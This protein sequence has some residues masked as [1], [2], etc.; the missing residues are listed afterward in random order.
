[1]VGVTLSRAVEGRCPVWL[2][3]PPCALLRVL[4]D[5]R[6][7]PPSDLGV[8]AAS[9]LDVCLGVCDEPSASWWRK[10]VEKEMQPESL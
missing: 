1:M 4:L 9:F 10:F 6:P 8:S 5:G 3:S 7:A 2:R